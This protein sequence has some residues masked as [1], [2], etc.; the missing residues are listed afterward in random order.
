MRK[1]TEQRLAK[2]TQEL[3]STQQSLE[4]QTQE[5]Q[6][7]LESMTE[8]LATVNAEG[9]FVIWNAGAAKLL[10]L[11]ATTLPA[12]AWAGHYGFFMNDTVTPF[13]V[14][15][16]PVLRALRGEVTRT[17]MFVRNERI[18]EGI[19]IEVYG[20]PMFNKEGAICGGVAAFRDITQLKEDERQIR[21]LNDN[22]ERRVAERTAELKTVTAEVSDRQFALDQHAIVAITDLRGTISYVNDKFCTLSKY[23]REELMGQN[24]RILNSGYHPKEFFREMYGTIARGKVWRAEIRNRAK[25]GSIYW[26]D[27]TIVPSLGLENKPRQYV[28]IRADITDRKSTRLNSSH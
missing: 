5:L 20:N 26:V 2:K 7:V 22:L 21:N 16:M 28:A 10:G 8:G 9:K 3:I 1:Q 24:H 25:D 17:E 6:S 4:A 27:T 18:P 13:P 23:S 15:Q 11:G 19:Y 14:D 12:Q